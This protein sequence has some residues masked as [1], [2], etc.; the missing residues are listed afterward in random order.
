MD[1]TIVEPVYSSREPILWNL[2]Q[3]NNSKNFSKSQAPVLLT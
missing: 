3:E 1:L 2:L